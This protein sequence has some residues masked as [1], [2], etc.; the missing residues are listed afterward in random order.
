M[1]IARQPRVDPSAYLPRLR[2][3]G[4]DIGNC[5]CGNEADEPV[6]VNVEKQMADVAVAVAVAFAD[7]S[8]ACQAKGT[9]EGR[10]EAFA[11]AE[12]SATAVGGAVSEIFASTETC[13]ECTAVIDAL[14]STA[15][16]IIAEAAGTAWPEVRRRLDSIT[17]AYTEKASLMCRFPGSK[18][19]TWSNASLADVCSCVA[20]THY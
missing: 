19:C 12:D 4:L 3:A 11:L 10:A 17:P 15:Q 18:S 16:E 6:V 5:V 13:S 9:A 14:P 2:S 1:I 8:A 7:V 20:N